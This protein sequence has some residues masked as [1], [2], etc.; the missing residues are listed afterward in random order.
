M[1]SGLRDGRQKTQPAEPTTPF[2]G[3]RVVVVD[4]ELTGLDEKRDCIVSIG[5]VRMTGG[6]IDIGDA[7]YQLVN[8]ETTLSAGSVVIHEIT[9]SEVAAKPP[10]EA[11][12]AEF[13]DYA[14][15]DILMGHFISLDLAFLNREMRRI[16][17]HEVRSPALDTYSIYEWLSR[18]LKSRGCF[19]TPPS[20]YRLYDIVKYFGIPVNG[21]HN[22]ISDAYTTA[23][24]FQRFL[25]LLAEAG[26][27]TREDLLRIGAPF[28]GGDRFAVDSEFSNF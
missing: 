4:T 15:N 12:L 8:P 2:A 23:Q 28:K 20:A 26:A 9:P 27:A 3:V 18:R 22:A 1:L 11:V 16:F 17:N 5:A 6:I 19:T 10:I 13:L 21:V 24:L 14:G 25:P 7:F